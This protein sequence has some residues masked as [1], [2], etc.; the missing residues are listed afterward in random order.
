MRQHMP[1]HYRDILPL[2]RRTKPQKAAAWKIGLQLFTFEGLDRLENELS[3]LATSI[4][5]FRKQLVESGLDQEA[6]EVMPWLA[7]LHRRSRAVA[8]I[9]RLKLDLPAGEQDFYDGPPDP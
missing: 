9:R 1:V 6:D 4:A 3:V 7:F 8:L 2:D 5:R